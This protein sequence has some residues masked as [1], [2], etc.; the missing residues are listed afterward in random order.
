MRSPYNKLLELVNSINAK[1]GHPV[2]H[3]FSDFGRNLFMDIDMGDGTF[4]NLTATVNN[5]KGI[6][7]KEHNDREQHHPG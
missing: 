6:Q 5:H 4:I 1:I 7:R 3:V 2:E